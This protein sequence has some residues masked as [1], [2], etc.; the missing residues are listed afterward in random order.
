[1]METLQ[2]G[3]KELNMLMGEV[4]EKDEENKVL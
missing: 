4:R 1:M 2:N 3:T